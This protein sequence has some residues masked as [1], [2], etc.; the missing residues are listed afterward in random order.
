[1]QVW[2]TAA[3]SQALQRRKVVVGDRTQF[4][5]SYRLC[6][7]F[8]LSICLWTSIKKTER[9]PENMGYSMATST[10]VRLISEQ[11][12]GGQWTKCCE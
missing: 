6:F 7:H 2:N 10:I 1:V 4:V 3:L 11:M 9:R 8:F 12:T 5:L